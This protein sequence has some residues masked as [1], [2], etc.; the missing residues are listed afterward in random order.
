MR[1]ACEGVKA[2]R[3]LRCEGVKMFMVFSSIWTRELSKNTFT[4]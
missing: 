3:L 1:F 4:S 2:L